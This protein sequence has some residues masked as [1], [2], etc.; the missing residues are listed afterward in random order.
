MLQP[1]VTLSSN[2]PAPGLSLRPQCVNPTPTCPSRACLLKIS[3]AALTP[4]PVR[5]KWHLCCAVQKFAATYEKAVFLTFHGNHSEGTK[6]LFETRLQTPMTP[7]FTFW[8]QGAL[9]ALCIGCI[10]LYITQS[11]AQA[12]YIVLLHV[13]ADLQ[14]LMFIMNS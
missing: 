7:T 9:P 3:N 1:F 2:L 13:S 8:R 6:H 4:R 5:L 10:M 11:I 14:L 12:A